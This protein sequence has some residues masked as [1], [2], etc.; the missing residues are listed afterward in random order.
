MCTGPLSTTSHI[1]ERER[2][3][4]NNTKSE[5][6]EEGAEGRKEKFIFLKRK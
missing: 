2:R 6:G 5:R 3:D 4:N 1:G